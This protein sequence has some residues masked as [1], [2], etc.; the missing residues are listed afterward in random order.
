MALQDENLRIRGRRAA[1]PAR[2][3]RL[4]L[5][6]ACLAALPALPA[7]AASDDFGVQVIHVFRGRHEGGIL[8]QGALVQAED[9]N[10]WGATREGGKA[11]DGA[12]FKIGMDGR[13]DITTKMPLLVGREPVGDLVDVAGTLYG[14]AT[15]GGDHDDGSIFQVREGKVALVHSF[16]STGWGGHPVGGLLHAGNGLLYGVLP[17]D[18]DKPAQVY[19]LDPA[20]LAWSPLAILPD[21]C[22]GYGSRLVQGA[23]GDLYGVAT[24]RSASCVWRVTLRGV[25]KALHHYRKGT[26]LEGLLAGS[27][28][29]LYGTMTGG[30]KPGSGMCGAIFRITLAG[31]STNLHE[32]ACDATGYPLPGIAQG[33]DG[34]LY[35]SA[36]H[37]ADDGTVS[38]TAWSL[39]SDGS[40]FTEL[41]MSLLDGQGMNTPILASDGALYATAPG[42]RYGQGTIVRITP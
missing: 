16:D 3:P 29:N 18:G 23:D 10:L 34:A 2:R 32:F 9:G 27:D 5:L 22:A 26:G 41:P 17:E 14:V 13:Y 42:G 39:A 1:L 20:T 4:A 30:G 28:G 7:Q 15:Q 11:E 40:T 21:D 37:Q 19:R 6:A 36:Y 33:P 8:P 35:G 12:I 24:S 31:V 25:F 38:Y